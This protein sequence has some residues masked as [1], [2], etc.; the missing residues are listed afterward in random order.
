MPFRYRKIFLFCQKSCNQGTLYLHRALR[1]EFLTTEAA[2]ARPFV[3]H[4]LSLLHNDRL[5]GAD[6]KADLAADA[7]V[8]FNSGL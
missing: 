7:F 4:R 6:L 8:P 5:G 1:A 2:Y 3:D